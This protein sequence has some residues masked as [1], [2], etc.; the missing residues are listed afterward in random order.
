M[1][2]GGGAAFLSMVLGPGPG[3]G[4]LGRGPGS[5]YVR[6]EGPL[7]WVGIGRAGAQGIMSCAMIVDESSP[8]TSE[9]P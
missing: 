4:C 5:R 8:Q 7:R 1:R 3:P 9:H 2:I 6:A